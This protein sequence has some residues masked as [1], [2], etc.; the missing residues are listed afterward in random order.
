V[1][2][3]ELQRETLNLARLLGYKIARFPM[4]NLTND[5]SPRRLQYDTKGF[6]D[7][8]LFRKGRHLLIEFKAAGRTLTTEQKKWDEWLADAGVEKHT[9]WPRDWAS[10]TIE[11]VL[12]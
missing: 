5:G 10:G 7:S 8:S 11:S 6:P 3:A 1:T 12:R 2:E 4:R 9:F